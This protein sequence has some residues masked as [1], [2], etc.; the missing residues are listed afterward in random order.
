[1][2]LN[3]LLAGELK[4]TLDIILS[5]LL[6]EIILRFDL[7]RRFLKRLNF[8]NP[9]TALALTLSLGSSKTGA[10]VLANALEKNLISEKVVIW[11]VLMLP[12]ISYLKRWPG[13]FL[14]STSMAGIAGSIFALFLLLRSAGRFFVA[15]SFLKKCDSPEIL[16]LKIEVQRHK[17]NLKSM[18]KKLA[19][20]L[21][22]SWLFFALAY[23]LIPYI[24]KILEGALKNNFVL[25]P[26][27]GW[28]IAAASI[29][30]ITAAL[31]LTNGALNSGA[32]NNFQALFALILGSA[33]G[34]LTR[35][36]RQDASYYFGLFKFRVA[37]KI[38]ILNF[39]TVIPFVIMS[40]I[41][42]Y[43]GLLF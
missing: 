15:L 33:L 31:A 13:T 43:I 39:L 6:G 37:L 34:I 11:S 17:F 8:I 20:S 22:I 18:F 26:F 2:A 30:H 42:A 5:L 41:F 23:S 19:R 27:E 7:A 9:T 25:I 28:T 16:N 29:S 36:L 32:L 40:L 24:N 4:L 12:F 10:G 35:I 3:N 1:M 38:L 21:P 14:M